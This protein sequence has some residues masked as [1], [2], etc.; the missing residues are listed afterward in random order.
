MNDFFS[1]VALCI[2]VSF[3]V[4]ACSEKGLQ[5]EI[6]EKKYSFKIGE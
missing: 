1:V 5:V 4:A 2:L 3:A 6:N